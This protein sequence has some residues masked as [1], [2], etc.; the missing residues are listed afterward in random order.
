MVAVYTLHRRCTLN[1]LVRCE[2]GVTLRGK[3][4]DELVG[5]VQKH[6]NEAHGVMVV[7]KEQVLA[8]AQPDPSYTN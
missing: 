7:T 4:D 8:M 2:C 5:N 1:K 6:I 3:D